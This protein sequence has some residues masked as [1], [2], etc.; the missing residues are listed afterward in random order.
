VRAS[1]AAR[2]YA[3]AL[4]SLAREERRVEAVREDLA[5][6]ARLLDDSPELRRAV[7]RPL[8]PGAQRRA[9]LRAVCARLGAGETVQKFCAFLVDQRRIIDFAGIRQAYDELAD[10]AEG[11]TRARV[12]SATPLR[13]DQR[14]RLKRALE[15]RT[16][17]SVELEEKVDAS[18]IGGA[19]AEVRG[20]VFD[21][22][23][24][25]QLRQLRTSLT[26]GH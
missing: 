10:E 8:H 21:G 7:L 20:L 25:T 2:R 16:G 14:A 12:T 4:F 15:A 17:R 3:R 19:I 1:A 5:G 18:L 13:E 22:S 24:R 9:V 23:L 6:L 26:R 11:R